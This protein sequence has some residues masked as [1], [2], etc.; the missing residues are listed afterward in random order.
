MK[1]ENENYIEEDNTA[2]IVK[3][4]EEKLTQNRGVF[5]DVFEFENIIDFYLADDNN[6]KTKQAIDIAERI[7]PSSSEIKLKKAEYYFVNGFHN[8]ALNI[9]NFLEKIDSQNYEIYF[10]K[11]QVYFEIADIQLS[12]DSFDRAIEIGTDDMV[13]LL[14][15]ISS[16]YL[17][18]DEIY[19]ALRYLLK[20]YQMDSTS[21]AVLFDMG[22]CYER[23]NELDKSI[24]Y[25]NK[26]LDLNPFSASA[27][28]NLGIVYTKLGK[29]S[30][31]IEAYDFCI[32]VDPT[33][34]SAYHNKG[35]T[36]ASIEKYAEAAKVFAELSELETDNPRVF[37]LLGE[38][39]EKTNRLDLALDNYNKSIVI[40]PEYAEGYYGIGI[41]MA[42]RQKYDISLN[43]IKRAIALDSE[44]YDFW[45]GLGRV[46]YDINNIPEAINAYREATTLNPDEPDAYLALAEVLLYQ[47]KFQ[48]VESLVDELGD[49]FDSNASIKVIN[50]AAL[51]L[52][53]HRKEALEILRDA[54]RI[55]PSSIDD[56]FNLVSIVN[57]DDFVENVKS[58]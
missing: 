37:A 49:K 47:E 23:N 53:Q 44:Q 55:D 14:Y 12:T 6:S 57:D 31:A 22:Y 24:V 54:K 16:F 58:L 18:S 34:S 28:Y 50:A 48:E 38:C 7:Y 27:W 3:R 26:Y 4:Y 51:Y 19:L 29:F 52:S 5:F 33:Y 36:L 9:L 1:E 25:Y 21:L 15:R 45:L 42:A 30:D 17:E 39:Y 56:F 41:V 2:E 13:D 32:A 11:G 20:S 43:F 8:E 46:Y 10:L 40:D 35:N